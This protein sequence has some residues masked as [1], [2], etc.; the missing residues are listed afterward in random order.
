MAG[1]GAKLTFVPATNRGGTP[2]AKAYSSLIGGR[3]RL[4]LLSLVANSSAQGR[5]SRSYGGDA[6]RIC[7]LK[8]S[9]TIFI[10]VSDIPGFDR[11]QQTEQPVSFLVPSL[12]A[13]AGSA[14]PNRRLGAKEPISSP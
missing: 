10:D 4:W 1:M 13:H 11:C 2:I 8:L 14:A 5:Q 7:C 12:R 6:V 9:L 3:N